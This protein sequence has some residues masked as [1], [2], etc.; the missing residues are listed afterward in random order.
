MENSR[1]L[2]VQDFARSLLAGHHYSSISQ[3][4]AQAESVLGFSI[5][6][7]DAWVKIVDEAMESAIVRSAQILITQEISTHQ[8]YDRLV[9]LL[10]QQPNLGVRTSTSILQQAYSTP[11][12]IA[13][14]AANLAQITDETT[15]YEPTAGNGALLINAN[16]RLVIANELN[17]DRF[18]ELSDRKFYQLM[19]ENAMTYRPQE[20]VDRVIANPPFGTV[21]N[22]DGEVQKFR[23][24]ETW[25]T[26]IDQVIAFNALECLKA[27]GKAVLILGGKLGNTEEGRSTRY[28]SQESRAFFKQLY[29]R[30]NVIDHFSIEGG[31]YRKQ[32]A[33]FPIDLIVIDGH[34]QSDRRLPAAD[35]PEIFTSF[36]ALKEKLIDVPIYR[37]SPDLESTRERIT[38][39]SQS[40]Q[41]TEIDREEELSSAHGIETGM[42]VIEGPKRGNQNP[43]DTDSR[44]VESS[45]G[46]STVQSTPM[47]E[48]MG[49]SVDSRDAGVLRSGGDSLL[50]LSSRTD[51][52]E[53]SR[54]SETLGTTRG[55]DASALAL[56]INQSLEDND[57]QASFEVKQ[58]NYLPRSQANAIGTLIPINMASSAQQ[59]LDSFEVKNG[60]IDDYLVQKLGYTSRDHLYQHFS[61]E[62]IDGAALAIASIEAGKGFVI[63]DQTGIGKG[64]ICAAVM[65]YAKEEGLEAIFVSQNPSL[66]ADI[67]RDVK[68]IG[69]TDFNPWMTDASK[70][71]PLPN[72]TVLRTG[73]VKQQEA[74][75]ERMMEVGETGHDAIFTTYSQVQ[76]IGDG[77]EPLRRDFLRA[78]APNAILVLDE[79]H[80]AGGSR[81]GW[82][83]KNE[84]PNRAAFVRELVD[85]AR[86]AFFSSA[87]A[88]KRP[89]VIDLYAR[90]T[91]LRHA[92]QDVEDLSILLDQGGVPLQQVVAAGMV[93]GGD[94]RRLERSYEGIS[95]QAKVVAVDRTVV[96]NLAAAMRAIKDFDEVKQGTVQALKEEAKEYAAA[97]S[98]D[99]A[100]GQTG[101]STTNFTS[102]MHNCISQT[103][104]ALKAEETVQTV[105]EQLRSG[106]KP[107]IALANTM[108]SFIG[109][110]AEE[111][112]LQPGQQIELSFGDLLNRYLDRSRDILVKDY[113][114]NSKRRSLSDSELGGLGRSAFEQA[115]EIIDS[116][117][118]SSIPI[119]PIDYIQSRLRAEGY[120]VGEVTGRKDIL[121]Y[122]ENGGTTY[123]VRSAAQLKA[124]AKI[125]TVR[126]FNSG[127]LDVVILNKSGA[128]GISLHASETF[129]DQR[130]RH[131]NILQAAGDI[132]EFVQMLGRVNRTGQVIPPN[133]SLIMA[134]I[135]AEKRP[136]AILMRKMA[137]LNANTTAAR[138]SNLSLSDV[139]DFMN[140]YGEQVVANLLSEDYEM[141]AALGHPFLKHTQSEICVSP[142]AL[143]EKVTGRIPLLPLA[144]Q[145]RLYTDIEEGYKSWV[146]TQQAIG[147]NQLEA[148]R[149]DLD[150]KTIAHMEYK[151]AIGDLSGPFSGA[152]QI[153]VIDVKSN[154]KP[155]TQ[156]QVT[157][158]VRESLG[159]TKIGT[160]EE[161]DFL[162]VENAA[163][164]QV[165]GRVCSLQEQADRYED[166][167][168]LRQRDP[169]SRDRFSGK[170]AE[171]V[172]DIATR[173]RT[174]PTGTSVVVRSPG[175][176]G[177]TLYGVVESVTRSHKSVNPAAASD[178]KMEVLVADSSQQVTIPFS[179]FK[180]D[181]KWTIDRADFNCYEQFDLNQT[182][183]R[184]QRQ[185]C[186]GNLI[187]A[188]DALHD[189]RFVH[190]TTSNG[191]VRQGLLMPRGFD[192]T[193][194]LNEQ[195]VN[196]KT[197]EN[198]RS[199]IND[200]SDGQ[201]IV[202]TQDDRLRIRQSKTGWIL[203]TPMSRDQG[204]RFFLDSDL[205]AAIG[206]DFVSCNGAM[207][208][209]IE[210]DK[211]EA[212]LSVVM[213]KHSL[214]S[215]NHHAIARH[216]MDVTLPEFVAVDEMVPDIEIQG[217]L[218]AIPTQ[219]LE[220]ENEN[221]T[222]EFI[223]EYV[224]EITTEDF[225]N[226]RKQSAEIGRSRRHLKEIS[227]LQARSET[228]PLSERAI[229]VRDDDHN[230]WQQM[231]GTIANQAQHILESK[232][233]T[234]P[235]GTVFQGNIY[236]IV[237]N[238]DQILIHASD[239]GEIFRLEQGNVTSNLKPED[240]DRFS[241]HIKFLE[242]R[243]VIPMAMER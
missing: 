72:G 64:R 150:A 47:A 218:F 200:W 232:G 10:K 143:I 69:M 161:H 102:L 144:E 196:L 118:F 158:S 11:I 149:L 55:G 146:S 137:F 23:T 96:E 121:N 20:K 135:P 164:K 98:E 211:I 167:V 185:V 58:V 168:S 33:G 194:S 124:N 26:Q 70:T 51:R 193:S 221:E 163:R 227:K 130:P 30:Y 7:G 222:F 203:S 114:G 151:P 170:L 74:A 41:R 101:I 90:K 28:H 2:L 157:Q 95:F 234:M 181:N 110:Y 75:M 134:D 199:F 208:A 237:G 233:I 243:A 115:R 209:T 66:Y 179:Q 35:V 166:Q 59:A 219:N 212:V 43:T 224:E 92:V 165:S 132:N 187:R 241:A 63:G 235:E 8:A 19:H 229:Q 140:P 239:R 48:G 112:D 45:Q 42:D 188:F 236:R 54:L 189:G 197:S 202:G 207:S 230:S 80:E 6:P 162:A 57:M 25:T 67:V 4:R 153:E 49:N 174:Y 155:L 16:P 78:I 39:S 180:G 18:A 117:D 86:G 82:T 113:A 56:Q 65:R 206:Q 81:G 93:E 145:E 176:S 127:E 238:D 85:A 225:D 79:A 191:E 123:Q 226:W 24:Y 107:V 216:F 198:V 15:V 88:I 61:A 9:E 228:E 133:Y 201:G 97:V 242:A 84:P 13:Y 83:N 231:V 139:V 120:R 40:L 171:Q 172:L 223:Y 183:S 213:A 73:T 129:S 94:M 190:F 195:P 108:G 141:D 125:E 22:I 31:L 5:R 37:Q 142:T 46:Y 215:A 147:D 89:D 178:W 38:L 126:Q 159:L 1:E 148:E 104:V 204:G 100:I 152:V 52:G 136:G 106:E 240:A 53:T 156:L 111:H 214:F 116:S 173:L 77:K 50:N 103:L 210:A 220:I 12:A 87:T 205:L 44:T 217:D 182:Q 60:N 119:S 71:I 36:D 160:I 186:T 131:M 169:E 99:N 122:Q 21:R 68:D 3:A 154:R 27:N 138:E 177:T 17:D 76:T 128:T 29:D 109:W 105:L 91:D 184:T 62:Q 175:S 14:L 34:G 192:A 32:G